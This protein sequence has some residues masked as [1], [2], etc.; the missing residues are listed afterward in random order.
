MALLIHNT[1]K[2]IQYTQ[3]ILDFIILAQYLFFNEKIFY[4]IEHA[5][6]WLEN[7]KIAFEY[8]EPIN[9]KLY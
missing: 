6:D 4:Y 9:L 5:L 2:V 7:N 1:L 3:V 8:Y